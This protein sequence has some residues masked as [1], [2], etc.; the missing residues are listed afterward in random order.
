MP[1]YD[2]SAHSSAPA[3]TIYTLLITPAT[4]PA[5][6]PIDAAEAEDG[7]P[8][9]AQGAGAVRIFRTGRIVSRE[10]ITALTP[11]HR[12]EYGGG[13]LRDYRASVTLTPTPGGGTDIRWSG[14]FANAGPLWRW[15]MAWFMRRMARG[16]AAYA[17]K[18][19]R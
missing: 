9:A 1:G 7:D 2:V 6:S 19:A 11:G 8:G 12:M 10:R 18:S 3:D 13:V 5:W 16:L 15:Y 17:E 14:T 4:W